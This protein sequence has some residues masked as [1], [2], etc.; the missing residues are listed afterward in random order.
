MDVQRVQQI[1]N[2]RET[3]EVLHNGTP[4]WIEGV[5]PG[6]NIAKIRSLQGKEATREVPVTELIEG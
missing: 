6:K 1:I 3:I 5:T 2:S 4:V